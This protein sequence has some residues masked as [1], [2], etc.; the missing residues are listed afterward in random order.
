MVPPRIAREIVVMTIILRT[1]S[2][3]QNLKGRGI[4]IQYRC[5]KAVAKAMTTGTSPNVAYLADRQWQAA[6][7]SSAP[8]CEAVIMVIHEFSYS[9]ANCIFHLSKRKFPLEF[10]NGSQVDS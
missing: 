8:P 10:K 9:H 1:G 6:R 2:G 7:P 5:G 3:E 4:K